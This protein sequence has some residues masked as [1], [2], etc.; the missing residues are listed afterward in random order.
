MQRAEFERLRDLPGKSIAEDIVL[1]R[2]KAGSPVL[3]SGAVPISAES[4]ILANLYLSVNEETDAKTVNIMI[5]GVGPICR[6][7]VDGKV[8]RPAGRSNK[9]TLRTAECPAENLARDVI[10]R[11]DLAGIS[12]DRVFA[13]FCE[14]AHIEFSGS[15]KFSG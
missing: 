10:D 11:P 14:M 3:E 6:L 2:K 9:H 8:H 12:V 13:E 5:V 4:G 1:K 15:L 7:D